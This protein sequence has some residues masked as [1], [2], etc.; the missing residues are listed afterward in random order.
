MDEFIIFKDL[1]YIGGI[2]G[3]LFGVYRMFSPIKSKGAEEQHIKD[4]LNNLEANVAKNRETDI[5]LFAKL[6]G[7]SED[8]HRIEKLLIEKYGDMNAR[9]SKLEVKG[10]EPVRER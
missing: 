1:A 6:D 7:M 5:K 3:S 10:C 4:R 2:C 8:V 9:V